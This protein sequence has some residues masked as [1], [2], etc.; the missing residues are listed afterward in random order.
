M[1]FVA[2]CYSSKDCVGDAERGSGRLGIVPPPGY[3]DTFS[4]EGGD[5]VTLK[6]TTETPVTATDAPDGATEL[7]MEKTG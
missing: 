1:P 7:F 3:Y 4:G 2:Y 6:A 5:A